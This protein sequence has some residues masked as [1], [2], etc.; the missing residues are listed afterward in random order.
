MSHLLDGK[1]AVVTGGASGIGRGISLELADHGANV[2]VA[3]LRPDPRVHDMAP[4]HEVIQ[5]EKDPEARYVET[6]VTDYDDVAAAV[7]VADG[8]GGIDV[9][10]NNAGLSSGG[11]FLDSTEEEYYETTDV[12]LKGTYFGCRAAGERM[13]ENGNGGSIINV[14][15]T[16][17][18]RGYES[19]GSFFYAGAKGGIRSMSY[20]IAEFLGPDGIRVN[21]IQPGYTLN[22][23]FS[24]DAANRMGEAEAEEFNRERAAETA[25]GRLGRPEDLGGAAVFLASD[26]SQ[27]V[28][29]AELLVDGGWV[30]TGGP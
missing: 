23:G 5:D 29:A 2:V 28:T 22:T 17:A 13:V 15:S 8:L 25:L 14:S 19:G 27:Y 20:S 24:T 30:H 10:V 16:A 26:L 6:D 7:D 4:T 1:T 9:M 11:D 18:D 21:S 3:D 12:M